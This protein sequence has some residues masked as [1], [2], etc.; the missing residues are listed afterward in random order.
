MTTV[1]VMGLLTGLLKQL[2][3]SMG[4]TSDMIC[5]YWQHL[6]FDN[7]SHARELCFD[8]LDLL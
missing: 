4:L 3:I 5:R 2:S 1:L 6:C 7:L 8:Q